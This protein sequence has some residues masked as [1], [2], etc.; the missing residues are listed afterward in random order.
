MMPKA[1]TGSHE[2][3]SMGP[4]EHVQDA[5]LAAR[6]AANT[7]VQA[8]NSAAS[9]SVY[10]GTHTYDVNIEL[11]LYM[12]LHI[13]MCMHTVCLYVRT[14]V[15]TYVRR[16]VC[17]H[18]CACVCVCVRVSIYVSNGDFLLASTNTTVPHP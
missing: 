10:F 15:R 4:S 12:D 17:T 8:A 7:M 16:Y 13:R 3:P 1:L 2:P 11:C 6:M 14:Y 5:R 18:V 9:I